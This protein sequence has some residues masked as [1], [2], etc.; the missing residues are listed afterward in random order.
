MA[1]GAPYA[2]TQAAG[3]VTSSSA[4]LNGM[5]M[6]NGGAVAWFE[7][8]TTLSFGQTTTQVIVGSGSA[9]VRLSAQINNLTP[10]GNFFCRIVARNGSGTSYGPPALFTTGRG[11]TAWGDDTYGQAEVPLGPK[12]VVTLAAGYYHNAAVTVDGTVVAWGSNSNGQTNVPAGLSNVMAIACGEGHCLAVK[13]D[14]TVVA[15]GLNSNGQTAV[16]SGLQGVV[17]V[18]GGTEHSLALKSDGTVAAWGGDTYGERDVPA[19]LAGVAAIAAGR[20]HS[21]ALK[22]D[23]TVVA[24]GRNSSGQATV[25]AGLSQVTA[26]AAGESHSLALTADGTVVA[27]GDNSFGQT[28]VPQGLANVVVVAA[29]ANNGLAVLMDGTMAAWGQND[30]GQS[31]VPPGWSAMVAVS[32]GYIHGLALG[33]LRPEALDETSAGVTLTDRSISLA[34]SDPDGDALSYRVTTLPTLGTLYQWTSTGR[35]GAITAPNTPVADVGGR[36]IYATATA[37][38]DGFN[39]VANDGVADSDAATVSLTTIPTWAYTRPARPAGPL[40]VTLYGTVVGGAG[41]KAWFEWGPFGGYGQTTV[42]TSIATPGTLTQVSSLLTGL[43]VSANYQYRIVVSNSAGVTF[44]SPMVFTSGRT[45]FAW[46]QNMYGQT[47][48]PSGLANVVAAGAGGYHSMALTSDGSVLAWGQNVFGQTTVP[49]GM[50]NVVALAGGDYHSLA[51]NSAGRVFAWGQNTYGQTNVPAGLGNVIAVGG[52]SAHCL[53]LKQDGTLVAWGQNNYGQTNIP[54]GLSNVVA[55]AT[56]DAGGSHNLALKADGTVVAWGFDA[57]GQAD[58]PAGLNNVVAVAHGQFH[59]LALKSDGTVVAWGSGGYGQ[60]NVPA[61]LTNVLAIVAGSYHSLALKADG[62]VVAWGLSGSGQTSVPTGLGDVA[63]LAAGALH[64]LAAGRLHPVALAQ[65]TAAIPLTDLTLTLAG[66]DPNGEALTY[67]I[68]TLPAAGTLY[69]WTPTGR[70]T[71]ITA[72]GTIVSDSSG[73]VIFALPSTDSASFTFIA[74][75]A[76]TASLPATVVVSLVH[77]PALTAGTT[78]VGP[79]SMFTLSFTDGSNV[80]FRVWVSYDL[81]TWSVVGTPTQTAPGYFQFTDV[82]STNLPFR[83]YRVTWP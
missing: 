43:G 3:P 25:P 16:P 72:P 27:W 48:V 64:S 18:A 79:N 13:S 50:G 63:P 6:P 59:S 34:G 14:G 42:A 71:R 82:Q 67:S 24:W 76:E 51:L 62:T 5:V 23:G 36:V 69:Q 28:T 32:G 19:G 83:F 56:G 37:G 47:N 33:D 31:I 74:T 39:F 10:Q 38:N 60:T 52:G 55:V 57:Y 41:T 8:G 54:A 26:V 7:W 80:R 45:I 75:D 61:G 35:G 30:N 81:S 20:Y 68:A 58:V 49:G 78:G 1:Q 17:A 65:M 66:T 11:V 15:W 53:A 73:Q 44:G 9:V 2:F 46:G 77:P 70:G 40:A 4:T 12:R 29:G 22:A 21:L